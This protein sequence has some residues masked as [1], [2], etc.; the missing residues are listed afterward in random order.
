MVC[1]VDR[2]WIMKIA[3]LCWLT[4][5]PCEAVCISKPRKYCKYP[6]SFIWNK[7][8]SVLLR[9]Y[10]PF[11][12]DRWWWYHWRTRRTVIPDDDLRRHIEGLFLHWMKRLTK[13]LAKFL[14]PILRGLFKTMK[15][16]SQPAKVIFWFMSNTKKKFH[17]HLFLHITL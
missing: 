3:H 6:W 17:I 5:I 8:G 12:L 1:T 15:R 2:S 10:I 11:I 16:F 14:K 9:Y 4:K 13:S 7:A